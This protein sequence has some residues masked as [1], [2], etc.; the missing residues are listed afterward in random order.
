MVAATCLN[1]AV[2]GGMRRLVLNLACLVAGTL[3]WGGVLGF[4]LRLETGFAVSLVC[5]LGLLAYVSSVGMIMFRQNQRLR[6]AR[7]AL[8]AG[9]EQFRFITEHAGDLVAMLDADG[10]WQ[11]CSPSFGEHFEA[12]LLRIGA[13]ALQLVHAADR[14]DLRAALQRMAETAEAAY[15]RLRLIGRRGE[16]RFVACDLNP[17]SDIP[18]RVTRVIMVARDLTESVRTDIDLRLA[19]H[20]FDSLVDGVLISEADGRIDY[21]N[22]AYSA[23][24]GYAPAEVI[25]KSTNELKSGLQPERFYEDIWQSIAQHGNWQGRS[26]ERR[27]NGTTF[28]AWISVSAVRD[29]TGAATHYVWIMREA[30]PDHRAQSA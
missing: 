1:S 5:L 15:L 3:A 16:T 29:A 12:G 27:R 4:P 18:G 25:G 30:K 13:D 8:R 28:P 20:A 10:R 11:Y 22:H 2:S 21:V 23:I 17:V 19:A 7:E 6:D 9:E 24:T 26:W 14:A